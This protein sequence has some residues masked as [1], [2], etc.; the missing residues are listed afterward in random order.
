MLVAHDV[1]DMLEPKWKGK[2]SKGLCPYKFG[3]FVVFTN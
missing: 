2:V 1:A 3:F